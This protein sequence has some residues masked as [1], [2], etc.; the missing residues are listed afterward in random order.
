MKM[1]SSTIR[2]IKRLYCT[3]IG[4]YSF[5]RNVNL[6]TQKQISI[7]TVTEKEAKKDLEMRLEHYKRKGYYYKESYKGLLGCGIVK[8]GLEGR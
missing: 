2:L 6:E 7:L 3:S 1:L 8:S 5:A 4:K